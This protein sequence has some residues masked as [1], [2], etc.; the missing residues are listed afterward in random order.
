MK[1]WLYCDG[2]GRLQGMN[3]NNMTGNTGWIEAVDASVLGEKPMS[4]PLHD[5]RGIARYKGVGGIVTART[6]EEMDA[7]Y[8]EP[9]TPVNPT[10]Y[11]ARITAL[12]KGKAEQTDVDALTEAIERGLSL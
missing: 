6:Q 2:E 5:S 8:V 11:D 10:D 12:E 3:P 9:E 7:D 4:V 1:L